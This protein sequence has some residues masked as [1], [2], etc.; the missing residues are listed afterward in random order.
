MSKARPINQ[1]SSR[2]GTP[3]SREEVYRKIMLI[4]RAYLTYYPRPFNKVLEERYGVSEARLCTVEQ[5]NDLVQYM[6]KQL[7]AVQ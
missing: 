3:P 6:E 5:L 4:Y 7:R 2:S 1:L